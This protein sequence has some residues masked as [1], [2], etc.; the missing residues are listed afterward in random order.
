MGCKPAKCCKKN[1]DTESIHSNIENEQPEDRYIR[2]EVGSGDKY[3]EVF[4]EE[5]ADQ[6]TVK[7]DPEELYDQVASDPNEIRNSA[8]YDETPQVTMKHLPVER[9]RSK[10]SLGYVNVAYK[11]EIE[12]PE[13]RIKDRQPSEIEKI[14]QPVM[15][16]LQR[17]LQSKTQKI[18]Q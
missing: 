2:P 14:H 10:D 3:L 11:P 8:V 18:K 9:N 6:N 5:N 13:T 16:E 4:G 7:Q 15:S 1:N 12:P 17:A